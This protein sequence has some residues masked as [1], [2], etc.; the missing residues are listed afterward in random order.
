[1]TALV[2]VGFA[3]A[4]AY[5]G[6]CRRIGGGGQSVEEDRIRKKRDRAWFVCPQWGDLIL[7]YYID[8]PEAG[9]S[10]KANPKML[11]KLRSRTPVAK[12]TLLKM[13][14]RFAERHDLG[15][16]PGTLVIDTRFP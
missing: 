4:A 13:L 1:M 15:A 10:L 5:V 14:H 12:S 6:L 9:Q 8:D 16:A 3:G 7:Q 2:V 11:A